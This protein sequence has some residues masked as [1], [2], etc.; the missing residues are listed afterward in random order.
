VANDDVVLYEKEDRLGI[1]TI[2]RPQ[3]KNA[4]S[5]PVFSALDKVLDKIAV[6]EEV[7]T[8]VVTGAGK[9]FVAGA[10]VNELPE[11]T[12]LGGWASSRYQQSVFT[13]LERIGKPS[14][15]AIG[16][17]C[18]GGGLELALSCTFR[19]A[20]SKAKIG[21]P[22]LGLGIMPGFGGTERA[23]R[24][25]GYAKAAD[26]LLSHLTIDGVEAYRIG[27]VHRVVEPDEV[28]PHAKEWGRRLASLS[29]VAVRLE[30][31]LLLH[32]Q[33]S[34]I[35]HGL[36]LESALGAMAVTSEEAKELLAKFLAKQG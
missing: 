24:T 15:A 1:I 26:L 20:S 2:N 19:V 34:A 16:A 36:A 22:E 33:G 12:I 23:V 9:G 21:F 31:E 18:L 3:V 29:P 30:L 5:M 28:L 14:I 8:L 6:D 35:D 25:L 11:H 13:K 27:L 17:F 7:R 32:G 10:D 4:L